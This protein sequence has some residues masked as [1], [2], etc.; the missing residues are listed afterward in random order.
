M[1]GHGIR[2]WLIFLGDVGLREQ[3]KRK[4]KEEGSLGSTLVVC[5]AIT[6]AV[7]MTKSKCALKLS[8][9]T[10]PADPGGGCW[11]GRSFSKRLWA[12]GEE[13]RSQQ[14][15]GGELGGMRGFASQGPGAVGQELWVLKLPGLV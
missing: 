2:G 1:A 5:S 3:G 14:E 8:P 15:S 12:S 6:M 13:S 9:R 4:M 11:D 7:W 10:F